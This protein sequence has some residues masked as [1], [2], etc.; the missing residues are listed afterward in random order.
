ME[1]SER[2][3]AMW[4]A[5]TLFLAIGALAV[6]ARVRLGAGRGVGLAVVGVVVSLIAGSLALVGVRVWIDGAR[7]T[8]FE[9][10]IGPTSWHIFNLLAVVVG[11]GGGW[12]LG[13]WFANGAGAG[14]GRELRAERPRK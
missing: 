14:A 10:R 8:L 3:G 7:G 6:L 4:W 13:R 12:L 1:F 2:S 5:A 11:A 9:D